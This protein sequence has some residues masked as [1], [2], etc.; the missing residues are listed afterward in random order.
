MKLH[1]ILTAALTLAVSGCTVYPKAGEQQAETPPRLI[2]KDDAKTW[3]NA[4]AFGPVP[5]ELQEAGVKACSSL[6]KDDRKFEAK[7]YHAKAEN[8]EGKA[9]PNGGFYCVPK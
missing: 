7:G 9:Y 6:D 8:L 3:D 4:G 5:S 2:I 1:L